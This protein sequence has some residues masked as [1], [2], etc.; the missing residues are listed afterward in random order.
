MT[1]NEFDAAAT[2]GDY[3][4]TDLLIVANRTQGIALGVTYAAEQSIAQVKLTEEDETNASDEW[5]NTAYRSH[6]RTLL[7]LNLT[8]DGKADSATNFLLTAPFSGLADLIDPLTLGL[9]PNGQFRT[10]ADVRTRVRRIIAEQ[11]ASATRSAATTAAPDVE[12]Y[13]WAARYLSPADN[14]WWAKAKASS[15][16]GDD[17]RERRGLNAHRRHVSLTGSTARPSSQRPRRSNRR[18]RAREPCGMRHPCIAPNA[19]R[20]LERLRCSGCRRSDRMGF[21]IVARHAGGNQR[22]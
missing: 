5:A 11:L 13:V 4:A 16:A 15:F 10:L 12:W 7:D 3:E 1:D 8:T 18:P 9:K 22:G 2:R 20:R 21:P 14:Q 19:R 6:E 17:N